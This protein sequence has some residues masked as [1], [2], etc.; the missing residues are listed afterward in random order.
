MLIGFPTIAGS[1]IVDNYHQFLESDAG[2][3]DFGILLDSLL[4][5]DEFSPVHYHLK[6]ADYYF[7]VGDL[8]KT[9]QALKTAIQQVP[10]SSTL[11]L[12]LAELY[13][14]VGQYTDAITMAQKV[15][16]KIP[17]SVQPHDVLGTAYLG[18]N[19][20][21]KAEREYR[22]VIEKAPELVIGYHHLG[23][24]YFSQKKPNA[25]LKY[26]GKALERDPKLI[27]AMVRSALILQ[28]S[29]KSQKAIEMGKQVLKEDSKEAFIYSVLG[30][31]YT[32]L[33]QFRDAEQA[34]REAG[35]RRPDFVYFQ[36]ILGEFYE[37]RGEVANAIETYRKILSTKPAH[38]RAH[39]RLSELY[40]QN[41]AP[42]LSEYHLGVIALANE[43]EAEAITH[44]EAAIKHDPTI[45]GAYLDLAVIYLQKG[46]TKRAEKW[47]RE[48][49]KLDDKDVVALTLLGQIL[50]AEDDK[51]G[52][53]MQFKRAIN[54]NA[55][56]VPSYIYLAGL[57]KELGRCDEAL[58]YYE[59]AT[60][61]MPNLLKASTEFRNCAQK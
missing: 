42:A 31:A 32:D 1:A 37:A 3:P 33:H 25:A 38:A 28:E 5:D 59:Q 54:S 26:Y 6:T 17:E 14:R 20:P 52:A 36:D 60:R 39:Y 58:L 24:L 12:T 15:L 53:E 43:R 4:G 16:E 8:P 49:L 35:R 22:R 10:G 55:N 11:K 51:P 56:Y 2:Q 40:R 7:S 61:T 46:E 34:Y 19:Q 27:D 50:L 30:S 57:L 18:L 21:E 29:G 9:I 41:G 45:K 47:A 23:D 48:T 13:N 44:Y